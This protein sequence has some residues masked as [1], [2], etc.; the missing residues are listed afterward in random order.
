MRPLLGAKSRN[1]TTNPNA[2]RSTPAKFVTPFKAGMRPGEKGRVALESA[3]KGKEN[4]RQVLSSSTTVSTQHRTGNIVNPGRG[5][6][7]DLWRAFDLGE[8]PTS[9]ARVSTRWRLILW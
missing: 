9:F 4:E 5:K 6:G 7:K 2:V 3:K 8:F 1:V